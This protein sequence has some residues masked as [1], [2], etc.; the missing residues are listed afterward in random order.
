MKLTV[1][2]DNNTFID[3][4]LLAEPGV[5]YLLEIN[6]RKILFDTGYSDIFIRNAQKNNI[7][8]LTLDYVVLSHGHLDH[9]WGL[10]PLI[11]LFTEALIEK[12]P[13]KIPKLIAHPTVL[14][15]KKVEHLPEIGSLLTE[16]KLKRFF[17]LQFSQE[18]QQLTDQ[19]YFLGEIEKTNDFEAQKPL[20]ETKLNNIRKKL[21]FFDKPKASKFELST[22][23]V[24]VASSIPGFFIKITP[25]R[26]T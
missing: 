11:Q 24:N 22:Y 20:G 8:L 10:V 7:D 1:L 19:L 18:S 2:V 6:D 9:T 4:Y 13:V 23:P 21:R 15:S 12:H 5:S 26:G 14:T 25:N 17:D 16:E 3:R